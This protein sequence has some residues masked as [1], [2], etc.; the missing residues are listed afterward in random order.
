MT[1]AAVQL[2]PPR[3]IVISARTLAQPLRQTPILGIDHHP[4]VPAPVGIITVSK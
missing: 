1:V 2:P 3:L 4:H